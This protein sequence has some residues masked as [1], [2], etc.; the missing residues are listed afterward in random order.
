MV[1][2]G[3]HSELPAY[4]R[5]ITSHFVTC[6]IPRALKLLYDVDVNESY[7]HMIQ[8]AQVPTLQPV[9]T[10]LSPFLSPFSESSEMHGTAVH[11]PSYQWPL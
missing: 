2:C 6:S 3:H 11:V 1:K 5:Y 9:I 7:R 8:C 4:H 10:T